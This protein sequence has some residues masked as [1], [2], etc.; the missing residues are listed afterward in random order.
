MIEKIENKIIRLKRKTNPKV[1]GLIFFCI[2]GFFVIFS[3]EMTNNFKR[4]KQL[5]QDEYNRSMYEMTSYIKNVDLELSKLQIISDKRLIIT[6]LADVWRQ[7]NLAKENL[8]NLPIIQ[9]KMGNTSKYLTQLSDYSH[10][11]MDQVSRG[12]EITAEQSE[13]IVKLNTS[14]TELLNVT[15]KIYEDLNSGRLKWDEVEK[16]GNKNLDE[17]VAVS[18][19]QSIVETFV[20]YEGLIYDGAYSNHIIEM[21][22]KN[23]SE[24]IVTQEQAKTNL[25]TIFGEENLEY[26]NFIGEN[27]NKLD[28]YEFQVKLKDNLIIRDVYM[29][30][31]DGK[32]YLMVSDKK[33][34][35]QKITIDN[36]KKLGE[37]FLEK[38]GIENVVDTYYIIT[39]NLVTINYAALQD[40]IILYPDLIK[41]KIALDDGEICSVETGGYT[42]NHTNRDNLTP[43]LTIE[44]AQSKINKS[45]KVESKNLAIVPTESKREL[46][47]YEFKG[48]VNEKKCIIYINALTGEEENVLMIIETPNG[49]LTM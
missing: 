24:N 35:E 20:E 30:K 17:N 9:E 48:T 6:T 39:E 10:S 18:N 40:Y 3:L 41:V 45:I 37:D 25:N 34:V 2:F 42:F 31:K 36:A 15:N 49:T 26:V 8:A 23:L 29:T 5:V 38:A 33:V 47:V 7:S 44:E 13:N 32:L 14:S 1:M 43:K 16:L 19:I 11:L 28:L 46:L 21:T 27:N 12:K 4:Q 22:P